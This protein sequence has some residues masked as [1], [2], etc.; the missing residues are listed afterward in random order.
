MTPIPRG[1][2]LL[3]LV[4]ALLALAAVLWLWTQFLQIPD[5]GW[6]GHPVGVAYG[7]LWLLAV[8]GTV[9]ASLAP[10]R[11][12]WPRLALWW[13]YGAAGLLLGFVVPGLFSIFPFMLLAGL[14]CLLTALLLAPRGRGLA[15]T[16]LV[17]ILITLG[18]LAV[19]AWSV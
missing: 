12:R 2:R 11:R 14:A 7:V 8:G 15:L 3:A 18:V 16:L 6:L 4:L 13:S 10:F 9:A 17:A 19:A 1:R 5:R